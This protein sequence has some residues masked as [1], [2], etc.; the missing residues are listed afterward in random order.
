MGTPLGAVL[1]KIAGVVVLVHG[2]SDV[3]PIEDRSCHLSGERW[4]SL[5]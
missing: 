2:L 1:C 4:G 3:L 5:P